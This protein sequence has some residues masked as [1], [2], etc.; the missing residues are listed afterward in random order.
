MEI[1]V[2]VCCRVSFINS[3][4]LSTR[5]EIFFVGNFNLDSLQKLTSR[6]LGALPG[7][8]RNEVGKDV[9]ERMPSGVIDSV[10]TRGEA[11]KSMVQ[12]IY[13]GQDQFHPDTSYLLQSLIDLAR[14]K[15]RESLR[16]EESG[17]YGV[18]VFGGQSKFPVEQYSIRISFNAFPI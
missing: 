11:P 7:N 16:E 17:V 6:Y 14:I 3:I 8:A 5:R 4:A 18:S 9:G 15:L 1:F 13:H 10:Y 2:N 12:L